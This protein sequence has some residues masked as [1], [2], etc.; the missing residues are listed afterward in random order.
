MSPSRIDRLTPL[1]TLG[2]D[3][4]MSLELRNRL[5][6]S[7]GLT[8]PA[9][10]VWNYPTIA[11]LAPYLAAR[12]GIMPDAEEKPSDTDSARDL[13]AILGEADKLS[14]DEL[15]RLAAGGHDG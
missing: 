13:M 10:L 5:E 7:T 4:L 2:L 8:L 14:E 11:A 6:A 3:S 15:R 12:M 9:T 1:P